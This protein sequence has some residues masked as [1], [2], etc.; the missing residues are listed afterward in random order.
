MP[1]KRDPQQGGTHADGSKSTMYCS[2]CY[3]HG[4]FTQPDITVE[5]MKV[6]VKGKLKAMGFPG[7]V[8]GVFTRHIPKLAR[9]KV[10]R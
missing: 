8:T 5:E 9:W 3:Q 4:K 6:L 10:N 1:L 7:I 2:H